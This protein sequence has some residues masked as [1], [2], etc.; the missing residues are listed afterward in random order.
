MKAERYIIDCI[1]EGEV[2]RAWQGLEDEYGPN[3]RLDVEAARDWIA[4]VAESITEEIADYLEEENL[5]AENPLN[6]TMEEAEALFVDI[7]DGEDEFI[8]G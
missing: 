2:R 5:L 7:D 6:Y 1:A 3:G 4:Y 8:M